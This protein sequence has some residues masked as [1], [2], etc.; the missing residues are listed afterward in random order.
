MSNECNCCL[1]LRNVFISLL[2]LRNELRWYFEKSVLAIMLISARLGL[3]LVQRTQG[4]VRSTNF[5]NTDMVWFTEGFVSFL[6]LLFQLDIR[7]SFC[8]IYQLR[9]K[10]TDEISL[11]PLDERQPRLGSGLDLDLV[12]GFFAGTTTV[13]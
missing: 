4:W 3:S 2:S 10:S 9:C 5:E 1:L 6:K 7:F 11:G 12:Q 13:L 8:Q